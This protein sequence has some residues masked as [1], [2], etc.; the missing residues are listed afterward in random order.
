MLYGKKLSGNFIN[1]NRGH[2]INSESTVRKIIVFKDAVHLG[3]LTSEQALA[4][5]AVLI[6]HI[7]V[8]IIKYKGINNKLGLLN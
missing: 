7:R 1:W 8:S 4:D 5:Y 6:D 2:K 3:Y